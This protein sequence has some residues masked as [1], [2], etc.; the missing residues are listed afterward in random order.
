MAL[1]S[2]PREERIRLAAIYTFHTEYLSLNHYISL[3]EVSKGTLLKMLQYVRKLAEEYNLQLEYTRTSGYMFEGSEMQQRQLLLDMLDYFYMRYSSIWGISEVFPFS[4]E[5]IRRS[6]EVIE[7]LEE[8]LNIRYSDHELEVLAVFRLYIE[9]RIQKG[10]LINEK[11]FLSHEIEKTD[12]YKVVRKDN[13][14]ILRSDHKYLGEIIYFSLLLLTADMESGNGEI[15]ILFSDILEYAKE[16]V[17]FFEEKACVKFES[18]EDATKAIYWQLVSAYFSM[19]YKFSRFC[20]WGI[21]EKASENSEVF[22]EIYNLTEKALESLEKKMRKKIP[23]RNRKSIALLMT[24]LLNYSSKRE[25]RNLKAVVICPHGLITSRILLEQLENIFPEVIFKGA[26]SFREYKKMEEEVDLI[27]TT[28]VLNTQKRQIVIGGGWEKL[29]REKLRQKVFLNQ[30]GDFES[31]GYKK[32][33]LK[34]K[35]E[36]SLSSLLTLDKIQLVESV[37]DWK[38]ATLI[39]GE[40]LLKTGDIEKEYLEEIIKE[41]DFQSPFCVFSGNL[42]IM[43]CGLL[44]YVN[45]LCMALLKVTKEVLFGEEIAVHIVIVLGTPNRVDQIKAVQAL[46]LLAKNEQDIKKI[47]GSSVKEEIIEVLRKYE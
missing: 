7:N 42:V 41:Y 26:C 1:Y 15:S 46:S 9:E 24:M 31:N 10:L 4:E 23:K 21:Q 34:N 20:V 12:I 45:R 38:E 16:I 17:S 30:A 47:K 40:M 32:T 18:F 37:S 44:K 13:Y 25:T 14:D 43:H 5:K 8:K 39:C 35:G 29:N 19:V 27:F 22:G 28:D 33:D 3:F 6:Y 11:N 36:Y 2:L